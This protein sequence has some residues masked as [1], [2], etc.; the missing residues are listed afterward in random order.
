MKLFVL[1]GLVAVEK[2]HLAVE[3]AQHFSQQDWSVIVLDNI[4]RIPLNTP[5]VTVKRVEGD[6]LPFLP[7]IMA[8]LEHDVAVLAISEQTH[9][10]GLAVALDRLHNQFD[11]MVIQTLALIDLRTCDCFP[12][13]REHLEAHADVV[14]MLPYNLNEVLSHVH[15]L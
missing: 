10:D 13:V 2:G 9:P 7:D 12:H 5:E 1:T 8:E 4:E 11:T 6:I 14:V 15:N 3:L